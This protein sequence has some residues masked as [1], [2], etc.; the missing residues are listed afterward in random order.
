M[1]Q[2]RQ[3]IRYGQNQEDIYGQGNYQP[4]INLMTNGV[5]PSLPFEF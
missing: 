1:L 5:N 2:E 4:L 3:R